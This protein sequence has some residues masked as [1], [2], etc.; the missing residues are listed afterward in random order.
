MASIIVFFKD[1]SNVSVKLLY[2][3]VVTICN[4]KWDDYGPNL[5]DIPLN[6]WSDFSNNGADFGLWKQIGELKYLPEG[7][8]TLTN[9]EPTVLCWE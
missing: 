5:P 7:L 8:T 9:T 4:D 6:F 2:A 3:R 1:A